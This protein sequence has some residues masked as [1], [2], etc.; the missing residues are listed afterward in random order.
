MGLSSLISISFSLGLTILCFSLILQVCFLFGSPSLCFVLEIPL[1]LFSFRSV[2]LSRRIIFEDF[3]RIRNCRKSILILIFASSPLAYLYFQSITLQPNNQDSLVYTLA[4]ILLYEDGGTLF[5]QT[6]SDY[7]QVCYPI[8]NDILYYLFLRFDIS[9]GTAFFSFLAYV[10]S[11]CATYS[12]VR[13][14]YSRETAGCCALIFACLPEIVYQSTTPKNDLMVVFLSLTTLLAFA[15]LAQKTSFGLL[16]FI[17]IP[18]WRN[19]GKNHFSCFC[20]AVYLVF[21]FWIIRKAKPLKPDSLESKH[22]PFF[23]LFLFACFF[24]KFGFSD[25]ISGHGELGAAPLFSR[26]KF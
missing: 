7:T 26:W 14:F 1:V 6:I 9:R 19:C 16:F 2:Y 3:E 23:A 21:L 17:S 8:G 13:T 25:T 10:G 11:I 12:L 20:L 18:S 5:P 15:K 4:R 22:E 24:R